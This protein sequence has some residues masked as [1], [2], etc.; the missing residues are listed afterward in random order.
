MP[1][2]RS[3]R[4]ISEL[5]AWT[6]G[7][8]PPDPRPSIRLGAL[9]FGWLWPSTRATPHRQTRRT[10]SGHLFQMSVHSVR[11][12]TASERTLLIRQRFAAESGKGPAAEGT[13][14]AAQR[15]ALGSVPS[16]RSAP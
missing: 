7:R 6:G 5:R 12:Y 4:R 3:R 14:K 8:A 15:R 9:E 1:G 10:A 13:T 11:V 2:Q 16:A